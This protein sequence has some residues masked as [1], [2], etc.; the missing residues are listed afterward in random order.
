MK[1]SALDAEIRKKEGRASLSRADIEAMQ[2]EKLNA[3]L[4]RERARGGFYAAVPERLQTLDELRR[5]PFTTAEELSAR[6]GAMLLLSQ[7]EVRRVIT[8]ETSGTSGLVKRVFY[9]ARDC[10]NTVEFFAAGL[11]EL[12]SHGGVTLIAMPFSGPYGL[13]ELIAQAIER[14]GARPVKAGASLS[15]G[16]YGALLRRER[17]DSFVGMTAQLLSL[18]RLFGRGTLRRA[19]VSGDACP[20]ALLSLIGGLGVELFPHY[21]SR[22]MALGGAVTCPAHCGMHLREEHVI[23][24]IIGEDGAPLQRG[25]SGELVITTVGMEAMPL[26]RYRTGDTAR[27]LPGLCPCGSALARLDGVCRRDNP[28]E[29]LDAALFALPELIDYRAERAGDALRLTALT[30]GEPESA[31]IRAAAAGLFPG[32][33]IEVGARRCKM[34]DRRL[35]AGKRALEKGEGNVLQ[36]SGQLL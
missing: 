16:E 29:A 28:M 13:G 18:L 25:E 14:L 20:P 5:L 31:R 36:D 11:S 17:P 8:G 33:R 32:K 10:E 6:G 4:A 7:S 22:E 35:Y 2:L 23:A 1:I 12:V 34:D 21:G 24:E 30:L 3:V 9:T 26:I 27:L 15:Y 19:L